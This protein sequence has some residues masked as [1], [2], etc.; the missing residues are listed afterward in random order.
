[1]KE[2][3]RLCPVCNNNYAN[4]IKNIRMQI[5]EKY[6]LPS[7]Y[8]IVCCEKCGFVYADTTA[9]D[10]DYDIYYSKYNTYSDGAD[11]MSNNRRIDMINDILQ[12]YFN[13]ES[14]LLDIGSGAGRFEEELI[15]G[16]YRN[17]TGMDPSFYS[18]K[19]LNEKGINGKLGSI[20]DVVE[21]NERKKYDG[22]FLFDVAEHLLSPKN[23]IENA[24][25]YVKDDGYFVIGVPN[26][27]KENEMPLPNN[28]NQEHINYFSE[29]SLENLMSK[30]GCRKIF[31]KNVDILNKANNYE[32]E[33]IQVYQRNSQYD[34]V[35]KKD[36][37]TEKSIK[38]YLS[39]QLNF[40][41]SKEKVIS[42]YVLS[43][44]PIMIWGT[45]AYTMSL[46]AQTDLSKCNI[47]AYIDNN[48]IKQGTNFL[49][50]SVYSDEYIESNKNV[51][52]FICA[53]AY[54]NEI[55]NQIKEKKYINKIIMI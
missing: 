22:V 34:V 16:G 10:K 4:I 20:Y 51:D 23:G 47:V 8:N 7:E 30:I 5:D 24:L 19:K 13:K 33:L 46:Y 27:S 54:K 38:R 9:L 41:K 45:G 28:F 14:L 32:Y 39:K 2:V 18:V 31:E 52:I 55:V 44:K 6:S 15:E 3:N 49:G 35:I 25:K 17:I 12:E 53:M 40:Y 36:V 1:M 26:Y 37:E 11:V 21:K 48:K 50:K 42:E 29:V 43:Q